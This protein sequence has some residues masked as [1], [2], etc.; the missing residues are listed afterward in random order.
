MKAIVCEKFA[1][2]DQLAYRHF[3]DPVAASDEV[4]VSVKACGVNYPDGLLVQGLY[5]AKPA[6]PFIPGSE[7][8]G[9][10]ESV[11]DNVT[12]YQVGDR[13]IGLSANYGA[14]AEKIACPASRLIPMPASMPFEDGANLVLAHGTSHYAL[15]QRGQLKPGE[16]LLV[17]GAAGGTGSAA[18]QIGKKMGA[19]VIA[20]CSSEEKLAA[21]KADGAD[22]LINYSEDDLRERVKDIT[23][24]KGVDVVYDPVGGDLFDSCTRLMAPEGRLLV[25]G[26]A[27]G[28]IPALPVNLALVK[29]YS[30]VGVFWGAWTKRSPKDFIANMG[31]LLAWYRDGSVKLN[32]D[33]SF[34]LKNTARALE[35]LMERKVRGKLVLLPKSDS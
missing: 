3:D 14:F 34:E 2:I 33:E 20:A 23:G 30:L 13:V 24:G 29:E 18:V 25:I 31:E 12:Q 8:S 22:E 1:P 11:G 28:R 21:A 5:Q 27:S 15:K 9:V 26:F 32:I 17:L 6:L 19:R 10:V 4:V 35:M 16:T 7:F